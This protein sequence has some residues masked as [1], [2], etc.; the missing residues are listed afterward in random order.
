MRGDHILLLSLCCSI[1]YVVVL[2]DLR[3][4]YLP[5]EIIG[6]VEQQW[7]KGRRIASVIAANQAAH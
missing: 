1:G 2:Y 6:A 3:C 4:D 7:V 5:Q